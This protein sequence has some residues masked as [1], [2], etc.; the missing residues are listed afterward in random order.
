M[1]TQDQ[2][3][4]ENVDAAIA[5]IISENLNAEDALQYI[6]NLPSSI[7]NTYCLVPCLELASSNS[8]SDIITFC[9]I[10]DCR[11]QSITK[12]IC[13]TDKCGSY[14][15][16]AWRDHSTEPMSCAHIY[17]KEINVR[18][19]LNCKSLSLIVSSGYYL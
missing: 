17:S 11:L 5:H 9:E 18:D 12:I 4:K 8:I 7:Y 19:G 10:D 3:V 15:N 1:T 14:M 13:E 2:I 16:V 6:A